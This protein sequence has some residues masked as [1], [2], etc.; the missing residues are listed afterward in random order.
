MANRRERTIPF[1]C[2]NRVPEEYKRLKLVR[3][4]KKQTKN[5]GGIPQGRDFLVETAS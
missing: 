4:S 3:L 5:N 2:A 1:C